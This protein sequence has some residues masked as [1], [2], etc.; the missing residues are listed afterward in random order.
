M[1]KLIEELRVKWQSL[2]IPDRKQYLASLSAKELRL[3]FLNPEVFLYDKQIPPDSSW[4]YHFFCGGRGTGKSFASTSWLYRKILDGAQEVAIVGPDYRSTMT[5]LLPIFISHFPPDLKPK[6][7]YN[8]KTYTCHNGCIVKVYSSDTEIRGLN[9]E[10]AIADELCK[11]N[12]SIPKK[13]EET[14]RIFSAGVRNKRAKPNPQIF[15]AST[16]KPFP[17]FQKLEK[18]F[19]EGNKDYSFIRA[20]YTENPNTSDEWKRAIA[21]ELQGRVA[22]Q[23]L[24][25]EILTDNPEAMWTNAVLDKCRLS[26]IQYDNLINNGTIKP[27]LSVVTID[28]AVSTDENSDETGIIV[29]TLD[30]NNKVYILDD[31]SG[32][33]S[34]AQWATIAIGQYKKYNASH[35]VMEKNQGGMLLETNIHTHDRYVRTKLIHASVGKATKFEPVVAAYER[36]D[37]YHVGDKSLL[38]DQMLNYNPLLQNKQKSP[39][40]IDAAAYAIYYLL[41]DRLPPVPRQTRNLGN[42]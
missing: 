39:D 36:G 26:K 2:P 40:R 32:K 16:P 38:E 28:P 3:M 41:L 17:I 4:R 1:D 9:A 11:W 33:H 5:E 15:I 7:N 35:I 10:Y 23:E 34:P 13:I 21:E 14:F 30:Q 37:V 6:F 29:A 18:R 22:R 12:Q 27:I 8:N 25:A 24:L 19:L 31:L 20:I 42:W